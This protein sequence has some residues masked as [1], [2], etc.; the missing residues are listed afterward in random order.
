VAALIPALIAELTQ[1]H[2]L[3][4]MIIYG[5]VFAGT[6]TRNCKLQNIF[7]LFCCCFFILPRIRDEIRPVYGLKSVTLGMGGGGE[8]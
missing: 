5:T 2:N 4:K 3:L 1:T 8:A 6:G 7:F